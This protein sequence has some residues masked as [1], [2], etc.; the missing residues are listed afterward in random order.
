MAREVARAQ[1]PEFRPAPPQH[2]YKVRTRRHTFV[3]QALGGGT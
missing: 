2:L 3:T 1:G